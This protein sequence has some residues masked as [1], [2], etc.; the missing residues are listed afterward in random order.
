MSKDQC[1]SC[2]KPAAE[3]ERCDRCESNFLAW[4]FGDPP[5]KTTYVPRVN[6]LKFDDACADII[7]VD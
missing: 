2:S 1:K 5:A 7:E 6:G 4:L 3:G